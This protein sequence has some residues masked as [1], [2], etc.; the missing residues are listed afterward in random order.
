VRAL[1]QRTIAHVLRDPAL[2][3][4]RVAVIG[5]FHIAPWRSTRVLSDSVNAINAWRP[6]LIALVGDYGHSIREFPAISRAWYRAALPRISRELSRLRAHDAVCAVLGNHDTD[7]G[8][9]SVTHALSEV[10]I[11]VLRDACHDIQ[12]GDALLRVAGVDDITRHG[13]HLGAAHFEPP[14]QHASAML[15]MSHHPDFVLECE[16]LARA[17]PLIVL[18]GHT[19]GGQIALPRFGAPITLSRVATHHFPGGFI[20]NEHASLYVTRGLGEQIPLRIGA[21][22]EITLLELAMR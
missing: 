11:R 15:V 1:A 3:G 20:P 17:C 6:D 4:Y 9:D 7:G 19:H 13:K 2:A 16:S 5:D 14:G 18:S 21:A 10:G 8:A 12:R 22:R